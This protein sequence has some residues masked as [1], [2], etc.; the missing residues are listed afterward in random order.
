MVGYTFGMPKRRTRKIPCLVRDGT[1]ST[2]VTLEDIGGMFGHPIWK[3]FDWT[4]EKRCPETTYEPKRVVLKDA[5]TL[6]GFI[7]GITSCEG[8]G[9]SGRR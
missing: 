2:E 9:R 7:H 1:G 3:C 6:R 8:V 4:C 5:V